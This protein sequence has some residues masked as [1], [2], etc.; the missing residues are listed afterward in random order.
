VINATTPPVINATTAPVINAT[1]AP[2]VNGSVSFRVKF[3]F[4]V[5]TL[6]LKKALSIPFNI[7]IVV[8]EIIEKIMLVSPFL[9]ALG[10]NIDRM[11]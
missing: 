6:I 5:C 4:I 9:Q 2:V 8:E 10:F 1:T 11:Q 7:R 3:V